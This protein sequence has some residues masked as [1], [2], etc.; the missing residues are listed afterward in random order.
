MTYE[1]PSCPDAGSQYVYAAIDY[2][3]TKVERFYVCKRCGSRTSV[4]W[5]PFSY[6][7]GLT[8]NGHA[9]GGQ[10]YE[11]CDKCF[12]SYTDWLAQGHDRYPSTGEDRE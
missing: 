12:L 3:T 9:D 8:E 1:P 2:T 5:H 7:C 10:Y 4:F 6:G 11:L